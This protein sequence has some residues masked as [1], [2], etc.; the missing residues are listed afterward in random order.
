MRLKKQNQE[1]QNACVQFEH[2]HK[3]SH[4]KYQELIN[5]KLKIEKDLFIQQSIC[6]QEKNAKFMAIN[7]IQELEG[8]DHVNNFRR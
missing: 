5:I 8:I 3:E 2:V 1:L 6:E 7:K 4:D